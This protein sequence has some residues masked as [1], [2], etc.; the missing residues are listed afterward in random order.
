MKLD[1]ISLI[2]GLVVPLSAF[3]CVL[4]TCLIIRRLRA[5]NGILYHQVSH[6]LDEEEIEFK[7]RILGND[8]PNGDYSS[9]YTDVEDDDG[10]VTF[11]ASEMNKLKI[12]ETYRNNLVAGAN[13]TLSKED[14]DRDNLRV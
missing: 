6:D 1:Q 9:A 13:A 8:G 3:I 10:E 2:I 4:M 11:S 12:L 5:N 7:H 14:R